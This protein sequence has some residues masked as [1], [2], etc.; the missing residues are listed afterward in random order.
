[1]NLLLL[2][3]IF[4]TLYV[5]SFITYTIIDKIKYF[6]TKKDVLEYVLLLILFFQYLTACFGWTYVLSEIFK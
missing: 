1:M 3:I 2:I 4:F 6:K 5:I